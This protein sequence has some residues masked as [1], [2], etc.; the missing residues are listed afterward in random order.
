MCEKKS[1]FDNESDELKAYKEIEE[2][3]GK[4]PPD[5]AWALYFVSS[6]AVRE[7][8]ATAVM[9]HIS[10]GNKGLVTEFPEFAHLYKPT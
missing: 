8:V 3:I 4:V 10:H 6:G 7:N 2:H 1:Y 9:T 5:E